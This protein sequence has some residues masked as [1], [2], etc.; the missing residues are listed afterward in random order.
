MEEL[1]NRGH[2]AL[3]SLRINT[4]NRKYKT[5]DYCCKDLTDYFISGIVYNEHVNLC[6]YDCRKHLRKAW[7]PYK[8]SL[9]GLF[10]AIIFT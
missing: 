1:K 3:K 6:S 8:L 10:K 9:V 4:N 7:R 2:R 5:C